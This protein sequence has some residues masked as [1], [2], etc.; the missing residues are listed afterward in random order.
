LIKGQLFFFARLFALSPVQASMSVAFGPPELRR[1][2]PG[3]REANSRFGASR[4][5]GKS[6][7]TRR[8]TMQL[9][10]R[11]EGRWE[12]EA[13]RVRKDGSVFWAHVVID[14]ITGD[15]GE[16]TGFAKITRD[17]TE[18]R[19]AQAER[20]SKKAVHAGVNPGGSHA[21]R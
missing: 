12:G 14:A 18:R 13:L 16:I 5:R 17:I 10:A 9:T 21:R 15:H 1:S 19:R 2:K 8:T 6:G 7:A 4:T 3:G 20:A 11:R